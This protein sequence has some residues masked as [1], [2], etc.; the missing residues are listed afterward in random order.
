MIIFLASFLSKDHLTYSVFS[1]VSNSLWQRDRLV[2]AFLL[3]CHLLVGEGKL[4]QNSLDQLVVFLQFL[5]RTIKSEGD[6]MDQ[7]SEATPEEKEDL[8]TEKKESDNKSEEKTT[9]KTIFRP[10]PEN[11]PWLNEWSWNYFIQFE[12]GFEEVK[13]KYY[14]AT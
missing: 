10:K 13:G 3:C 2:F 5:K 4:D 9:P 7:K 14:L 12:D 11:L 8:Q 1:Q 6:S